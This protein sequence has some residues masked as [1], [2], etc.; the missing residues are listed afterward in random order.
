M[1]ARYGCGWLLVLLPLACS[2]AEPTRPYVPVLDPAS[3]AGPEPAYEAPP[4]LLE[5]AVPRE[6]PSRKPVKAPAR[7]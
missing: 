5:G 4:N 3:S 1:A 6:P 2:S 7:R